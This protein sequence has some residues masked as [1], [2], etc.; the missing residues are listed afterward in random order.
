MIIIPAIDL[1]DGKCVRLYQGKLNEQ[2]V[3]SENPP[4]IARQW[5]TAGA[6][7]LHVVDL[8]GAFEGSP[9]NLDVVCEIARTISIPVQLG[10]GIRNK[11]LVEEIFANNV[12][13]VVLGTS[14]IQDPELV[15]QLATSFPKRIVLGIDAKEG[16]V[17]VKGWTEVTKLK[18]TQLVA[19]FAD[20][21][22]AGIVFTD[23]KCDGTLK[24]P[25]LTSLQEM[26]NATDIPV[27][28]SGGI[29]TEKD[30]KRIAERFSKEVMGIIVGKALYAG[31]VNLHKV[32][33][34]YQTDKT[35]SD[36]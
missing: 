29:G 26:V 1:Y 19:Q 4:V 34:K 11:D 13:R 7:M 14:A 32:I 10:G 30:I 16:F 20:T 17:A 18:A 23:I 3:Y 31:A 22:L 9:R 21:P 6:K 36:S 33:K 35:R 27:I 25:N 2:T 12:E 8:N 5:E 24:G 15:C 28:A